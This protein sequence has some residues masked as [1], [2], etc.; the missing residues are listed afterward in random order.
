MILRYTCNMKK[1][2]QFSKREKEVIALLSQGKSNKEIAFTLGIAVR[3]VEFHLSNIYTKLD[4]N[5]RTEAVLKLSET[6]L[7][8]STGEQLRES[9]GHNKAD[10]VHNGEVSIPKRRLPMKKIFLSIVLLTTVFFG[11]FAVANFSSKEEEPFLAAPTSTVTATSMP[12][13][14]TKTPVPT[15]SAK[16]HIVEQIRE[17]VAEY[18][19]AVQSEKKNGEVEFSTDPITGEELFFF[20]GESYMTIMRLYSELGE[21][22]NALNLLYTQLYRDELNPTPFPTQSSDQESQA[23][24]ETLTSQV[25]SY[26][27]DVRGINVA[28]SDILL[29]WLDEGK[30]LP[31]MFGDAYA[32]CETYG[33]MIQEWSVAPEL[34]KINQDAD[35]ALIRQVMGKP[36]LTLRFER[37]MNIANAFHRTAAIYVDDT[38]TKYYVDIDTGRLA[39]IE[40]NFPG[41]PNVSESEAKSM[42]ELR[43]I[44]R[45]FAITNSLRL[46]ELESVLLYEEGC[47]DDTLCFFRWDYRNKDWSGTDWFIMPPFLQVGVLRNGQIAVYINTLDLFEDVPENTTTQ[48]PEEILQ[49]LN[50]IAAKRLSPGWVHIHTEIVSDND[51]GNHGVLPNG[52]AIP[53]HQV[54][55]FWVLVNEDKLVTESVS[56]MRSADGEI[57][58]VGT[59]LNG[60][61]NNSVIDD[62][63]SQEPSSISFDRNFLS[64]LRRFQEHGEIVTFRE[65]VDED[66]KTKIE[67][68]SSS[69]FEVP[70]KMVD[71]DQSLISMETHVVF[72]KENGVL[73]SKETI[74][75]L[76]DGT[77]RI[78]QKLTQ[79]ITFDPPDAEALAFLK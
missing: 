11:I 12:T 51:A 38:G 42:D 33:Q 19:Q 8:E 14:P 54:N 10:A 55:D 36:E 25:P 63:V 43:G 50:G 17:L 30:Y 76:E 6:V 24:Y 5:S 56:I 59:Y 49:S 69:I 27:E 18:D 65:F 9:T 37:V 7:R 53:L 2:E 58:Q 64:D 79:E 74:A 67:F 52:A 75:H 72:D 29:Y 4:V 60:I 48:S 39:T 16:E 35:M 31:L 32:R 34:E 13:T 26:C 71:Y 77:E 23:F 15:V 70:I 21:N 22:I 20:T 40:P 66:G 57:V 78:V 62:P 41:H 44:A 3:T 61:S 45:Q 28:E 46:G 68:S 47:K 73:L 1:I